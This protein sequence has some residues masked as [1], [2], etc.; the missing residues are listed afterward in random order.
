MGNYILRNTNSIIAMQFA[1]IGLF[2]IFPIGG[3]PYWAS[4]SWG[5]L[6]LIVAF[7]FWISKEST[8]NTAYFL[9]AL[10]MFTIVIQLIGRF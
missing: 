6:N 8:S 10:N 1:L 3:L 2:F 9:I 7:I 4:F 5:I